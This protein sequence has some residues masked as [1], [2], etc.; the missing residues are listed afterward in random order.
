MLAR[1][2]SWGYLH[3]TVRIMALYWLEI[4]SL[5]DIFIS[6]IYKTFKERQHPQP[7]NIELTINLHILI[8]VNKTVNPVRHWLL[9][10]LPRKPWL[11]GIVGLCAF[12]VNG[13]FSPN[14]KNFKIKAKSLAHWQVDISRP[15][16]DSSVFHSRRKKMHIIEYPLE[17]LCTD[18]SNAL[19]TI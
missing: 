18:T 4:P 12:G 16:G 8:Y 2:P 1:L 10:A 14:F 13:L 5:Y 9:N 15:W 7:T 6:L 19:E 17:C 3:T 11:R